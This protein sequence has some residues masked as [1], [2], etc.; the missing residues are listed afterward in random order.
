MM[1]PYLKKDKW[2]IS[3]EPGEVV[4]NASPDVQLQDH[5]VENLMISLEKKDHSKIKED[6]IALIHAI[7]NEE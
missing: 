2:P 6:L 7:L 5:L 3:K 4:V 1:L